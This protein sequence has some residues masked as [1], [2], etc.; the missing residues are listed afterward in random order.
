MQLELWAFMRIQ[1]DAILSGDEE[2]WL[3]LHEKDPYGW[4][5]FYFPNDYLYANNAGELVDSARNGAMTF[6]AD[7]EILNK[8]IMNII[9]T[10]LIPAGRYQA[11]IIPYGKDSVVCVNYGTTL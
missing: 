1:I 2:C 11:T 6:H 4:L 3:E 9:G 8:E 5:K 10:D 7:C